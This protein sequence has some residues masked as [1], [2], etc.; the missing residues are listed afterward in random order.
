MAFFLFQVFQT[1]ELDL[2]LFEGFADSCAVPH[3]KDCFKQARQLVALFR[4]PRP[5]Q[6]MDVT[7]RFVCARDTMCMHDMWVWVGECMYIYIRVSR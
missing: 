7:V 4:L 5:E 2:V 6:Y 3:L 1:L